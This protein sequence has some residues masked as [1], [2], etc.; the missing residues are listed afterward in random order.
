[1]FG[2]RKD[3]QYQNYIQW[4]FTGIPNPKCG[5]GSKQQTGTPK[6]GI[7][8]KFKKKG[9]NKF[10]NILLPNMKMITYNNVI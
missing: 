5:N 7:N 1:M 8:P 9:R 10:Q 4:T 3:T 2:C 6:M